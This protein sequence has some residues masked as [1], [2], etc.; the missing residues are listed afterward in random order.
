MV[1]SWRGFSIRS[2]NGAPIRTWTCRS[3]TNAKHNRKWDLTG[4]NQILTAQSIINHLPILPH[5]FW[6]PPTNDWPSGEPTPP[7]SVLKM[8]AR[9]QEKTTNSERRPEQR[10]ICW[11]ILAHT[12]HL[13]YH[14]PS[15]RLPISIVHQEHEGD[16]HTYLAV[17]VGDILA[18]GV[19]MRDGPRAKRFERRFSTRI[20]VCV[21]PD[22]GL[23]CGECSERR[24][25]EYPESC[26]FESTAL[27]VSWEIRQDAPDRS[28]NY[29]TWLRKLWPTSFYNGNDET[30]LMKLTFVI[31]QRRN[32]VDMVYHQVDTW[33]I[34]M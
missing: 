7:H 23:N 27:R 20:Y 8:S 33:N 21:L 29:L 1:D 16:P 6:L 22:F 31:G 19:E 28:S 24:P 32:T 13:V 14:T 9:T 18:N 12:T 15:G 2:M 11:K 26:P 30:Y 4:T 10:Q 25:D 17:P 5:T 3:G 34:C